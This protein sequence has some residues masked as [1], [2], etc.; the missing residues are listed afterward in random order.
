[1]ELSVLAL[2]AANIALWAID[3]VS[4][5]ALEKAGADVLEFLTKRFQGKLQVRGTK[6]ELLEAA[7]LSE[8]EQDGEF[9]NNLEK[10]VNQYQQIQNNSVSQ[11]T[12]SGVNVNVWNNPGTV[13]GQQIGQQFFR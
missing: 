9:R 13:I 8:A 12:Q 3:K 5:G 11:N 7:I 10:L 2:Q 1:M 4:G 6:P